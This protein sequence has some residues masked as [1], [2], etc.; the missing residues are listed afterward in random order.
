MTL[1]D[2]DRTGTLTRGER[3]GQCQSCAAKRRFTMPFVKAA[4]LSAERFDKAD[5]EASYDGKAVT[6]RM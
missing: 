1:I 3:I 4:V 6:V 2:D 5:K